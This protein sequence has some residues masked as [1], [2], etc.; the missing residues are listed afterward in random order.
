VPASKAIVG[1]FIFIAILRR[2]MTFF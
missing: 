2:D 1:G